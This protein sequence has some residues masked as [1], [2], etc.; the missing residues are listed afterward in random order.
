MLSKSSPLTT[1]AQS[2][3]VVT[4]EVRRVVNRYVYRGAIAP[5]DREDVSQELHLYVLENW[6]KIK[7][8]YDPSR[9]HLGPYLSVLLR[10]KFLRAFGA[11]RPAMAAQGV[12]PADLKTTG[13][14]SVEVLQDWLEGLS[15]EVQEGLQVA[16]LDAGKWRLL[17]QVYAGKVLQ[18]SDLRAYAPKVD[19]RRLRSYLS[20]FGQPYAHHD[21]QDNVAL[22]RPLLELVEGKPWKLGAVIRGLNVRI[23]Q[24]QTWLEQHTPYPSD[25][26]SIRN[27]LYLIL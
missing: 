4:T 7:A 19:G 25:R 15:S 16:E 14:L 1:W 13:T 6:S 17:G 20:D 18:M 11:R 22:L 10:H 5:S 8:R 21:H 3:P 23:H 24:L 27:L 2:A 12:V 26:E 9:G